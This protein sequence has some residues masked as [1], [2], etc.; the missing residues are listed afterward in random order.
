VLSKA[1]REVEGILGKESAR[2]MV[3]E[4]PRRILA[5]DHVT[6]DKPVP[7]EYA[8]S[9]VSVSYK[10]FSFLGLAGKARVG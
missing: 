5:G 4:T 2:C 9:L 1:L 6:P 10:I 8:S 3:E 7:F